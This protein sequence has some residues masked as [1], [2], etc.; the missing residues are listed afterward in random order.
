MYHKKFIL[1]QLLE[2]QVFMHTAVLNS[3]VS[4]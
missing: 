1:S 3:Y 4:C 2:K